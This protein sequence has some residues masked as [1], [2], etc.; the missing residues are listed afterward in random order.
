VA[1]FGIGSAD[2]ISAAF[3]EFKGSQKAGHAAHPAC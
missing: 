3:S 1:L 2:M